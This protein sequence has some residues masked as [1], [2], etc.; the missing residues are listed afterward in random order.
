MLV[1]GAFES[2]AGMRSERP[3]AADEKEKLLHLPPLF[4]LLGHGLGLEGA[5]DLNRVA[6]RSPC[7]AV[8]VWRIAGV[9]LRGHLMGRIV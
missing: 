2:Y 3:A 7:C 4:V 5:T 6:F 9:G 1:F 8:G